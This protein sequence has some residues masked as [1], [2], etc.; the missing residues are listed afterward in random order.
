MPWQKVEF[1]P[2]PAHLSANQTFSY[3]NQAAAAL[4]G[5]GSR[6]LFLALEE[7][8]ISP[9]TPR[10]REPPGGGGWGRWK[11]FVASGRG[12]RGKCLLYLS[13]S[14]PRPPEL[15]SK[16]IFFVTYNL[17]ACFWKNGKNQEYS[18]KAKRGGGELFSHP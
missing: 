8:D 17:L 14:S 2:L 11:T 4:G 18:N 5:E 9:V 1:F 16:E 10:F 13:L 15:P 6:K 12:E 7:D 3:S